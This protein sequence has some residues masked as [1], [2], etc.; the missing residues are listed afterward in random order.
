MFGKNQ[1]TRKSNSSLIE[2][3][4]RDQIDELIRQNKQIK[5]DFLVMQE[6]F[7]MK[8]RET[9][10]YKQKL[11]R[12][13]GY[14]DE[15]AYIVETKTTPGLHVSLAKLVRKIETENKQHENTIG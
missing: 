8:T 4:L 11:V 15:L 13:C 9:L 10:R 6:N 2:N 14:I 7:R 1:K 3:E 5:E 12:V